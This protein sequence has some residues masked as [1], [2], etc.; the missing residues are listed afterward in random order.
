MAAPYAEQIRGILPSARLGLTD[1][2]LIVTERRIVGAKIG[3]SG[4]AAIAGGLIGTAVSLSGQ[5][6]KR[7]AYGGMGVDQILASNKKN[8]Q[9]PLQSVQKG[10]F[11]GG[12]SMVTLPTLT[13]WT[14]SGKMKFMFTHSMWS[15]DAQKVDAAR[16]LLAAVFPGRMEFKRV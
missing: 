16:N 10:L 11:N 14:D 12:V 9:I 8:F 4:A 7:A 1:Y 2:D 13:L 6:S 5:D 3:S 15:K